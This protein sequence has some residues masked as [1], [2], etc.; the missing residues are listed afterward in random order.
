MN[1]DIAGRIAK[2]RE[3]AEGLMDTLPGF[4]LP[5]MELADNLEN[6]LKERAT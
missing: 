3:Y 6:D 2:L 4:A 5:L 1:T